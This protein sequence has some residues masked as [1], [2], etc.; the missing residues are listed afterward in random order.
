M[1]RSILENPKLARNP[2][3]T[4]EREVGVFTACWKKRLDKIFRSLMPNH[5]SDKNFLW[6]DSAAGIND[7]VKNLNREQFDLQEIEYLI[8]S[9]PIHDLYDIIEFFSLLR[10]KMPEH[11]RVLFTSYSF[12]W[13]PVFRLGSLLGLSRN[14]PD[15]RFYLEKDIDTFIEV[16]GWESTRKLR[17]FFFPCHV[18]IFSQ[19]IDRV[20]IRLPI[21]RF[22]ALNTIFIAR[23]RQTEKI[24]DYSVTVLVPCKNEENNVA[25]IVDRMPRFGK[26]VE[27]LFVNDKS[28]DR[29]E[30][31]LRALSPR[32]SEQKIT[33]VQGEGRGKGRAIKVGMNQAS[34]DIC[35]ILDADLAV[36][37]EDLPQFYTTI[38]SR[39]A[40]FLH[41][42]RM[43]YPLEK[44]AMRYLNLLGNIGFAVLFSYI[45]EQRITDTLC[46]TKVFWRRDWP[47]FED[48]RLRLGDVDIWGDY[49]L[50]FGAAYFGL[51]VSQLPVRYFDRLEGE[52]KMTRRL[53]NA[54]IMLRVAWKAMWNIKF[55][56]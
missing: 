3:L 20:L 45:L 21:F 22:F 19:I 27:I 25:A 52:S 54:A 23:V 2:S 13:S 30:T 44:D 37:P 55:V 16:A 42:T 7:F 8:I 4:G 17:P 1:K 24:Q 29:T 31:R 40:D 53:G 56:I 38:K 34:G 41:G 46:G 50:I 39:Y 6:L 5:L 48:I 35:M 12:F 10:S 9:E 49:N 36:I 26:S 32:N 15:S 43:V 18:P 51:K 11:G 33:L 14:R 47:L 28:T